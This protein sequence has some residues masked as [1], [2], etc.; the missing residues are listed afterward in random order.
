MFKKLQ[1]KRLKKYQ[2][3][4]RTWAMIYNDRNEKRN[5]AIRDLADNNAR[6]V[7][8]IRNFGIASADAAQ[9]LYE[10]FRKVAKQLN[11]NLSEG[12]ENENE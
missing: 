9:T 6:A 1:E 10:G 11:V 2:L 3:S 12:D 5:K 8:A 7:E 4:D